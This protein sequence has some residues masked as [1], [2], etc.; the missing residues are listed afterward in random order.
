MS[1]KTRLPVD[2]ISPLTIGSADV[3]RYG[4]MPLGGELTLEALTRPLLSVL[5]RLTKCES[6][7]LIIFDWRSRE[8][9]VEF[10][11]SAGE[12][13]VDE[14]MRMPLSTELRQETFPGVT[15]SPMTVS[16][17][18]ADGW[19]AQALGLKGYISVPITLGKHQLFGML[20]G[21]SRIAYD[22]NESVANMF[23]YFADIIAQH[24][25][26]AETIGLEERVRIAEERW[27]ERARFVAQAQHQMKTPLS[28]LQ[29]MSQTLRNRW[30][31]L[32][33]AEQA[34]MLDAIVA[35]SI[36]LTGQ[37]DALLVEARTYISLSSL[38]AVDLDLTAL[39]RTSAT[40]FDGLD[41]G[42]HVTL[43]APNGVMAHVDRDATVQ[44]LGH[45]LDNAIKYSPDGGSI[46]VR[47]NESDGGSVAIEVSDE[48]VGLPGNVD[49]FAAFMRARP[50]EERAPGVG[51][52]LHIVRTLVQAMGGT[53]S[54]QSNPG[55]GATFEVT[56]PA[57]H[58]PGR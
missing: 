2:P 37:V 45:L 39:A 8:Q 48:G 29:G 23:E 51:L 42:H 36:A 31:Q 32:T 17:F 11:F 7:Y 25:V 24:I 40:A 4:Q 55:K 6:T 19:V 9:V 3:V 28:T 57:G 22:V 47:V 1:K 54:A 14:G 38:D 16:D 27:A 26:R 58:E 15:R 20:C 56:L 34:E 50:H 49:I 33:R 43:V 46:I 13:Q 5:A 44:V 52:G 12:V 10:V 30:G 53:V 41:R 35:S 18:Q 21:A